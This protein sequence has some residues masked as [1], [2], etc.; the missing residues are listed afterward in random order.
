MK[1]PSLPISI[2]VGVIAVASSASNARDLPDPLAGYEQL[3]PVQERSVVG[4]WNIDDA[5]CTGAIV[6]G[7]GKTYWATV[8]DIST[9]IG[10]GTGGRVLQAIGPNTFID[11][12]LE[13]T[14]TI[15]SD[16]SLR[17]SSLDGPDQVYSARLNANS[18]SWRDLSWQWRLA[19]PAPHTA[20]NSAPDGLP[21][22]GQSACA[23][24][25]VATADQAVCLGRQVAEKLVPPSLELEFK[26]KEAASHWL[27]SF[28]PK[29]GADVF[30][31]AGD[32][33]IEKKSGEVRLMR[34][35][36]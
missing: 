15:Q 13:T 32:L 14:Y 25:P 34:G 11:R 24:P 26:A 30:G 29:P 2:F 4:E 27:V 22:R 6:T 28:G 17:V 36:K 35:Y 19:L 8:C 23:A 31:G 5:I 9:G 1:T 18:P 10:N 7:R 21:S 16:G 20:S 3:P 33:R 12:I